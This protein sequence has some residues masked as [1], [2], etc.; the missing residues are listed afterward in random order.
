M[1]PN[2]RPRAVRHLESLEVRQLLSASS[3]KASALIGGQA[4]SK[5][6][7]VAKA[8]PVLPGSPGTDDPSTYWIFTRGESIDRAGQTVKVAVPLTS[9]YVSPPQGRKTTNFEFRITP[10]QGPLAPFAV[11][12][13]G[14]TGKAVSNVS[15]YRSGDVI[16]GVVRLA[17]ADYTIVVRG[18]GKSTGAFLAQVHLVG[19]ETGARTVTQGD[20][21]AIR[22]VL[23]T[24][25]GSVRD[26]AATAVDDLNDNGRISAADLALVRQ[27]LGAEDTT[28]QYLIQN[29]TN[30]I[31]SNQIHLAFYGKTSATGPFQYFDLSTDK[32]AS[33]KDN[34]SKFPVISGTS[35]HYIPNFTLDKVPNGIEIP[36]SF[37]NISG[38]LPIAIGNDIIATVNPDGTVA[39]PTPNNASDPNS[40]RIWELAEATQQ[41]TSQGWNVNADTSS[42]D[43]FGFPVTVQLTPVDIKHPG[44]AGVFLN[45]ASLIKKFLQGAVGGLAPFQL[46]VTDA[47]TTAD[48]ISG[49]LVPYR[50]LSPQ[51]VLKLARPSGPAGAEYDALNSYFDKSIN[52][53][54]TTY[55]SQSLTLYSV[56]GKTA[57]TGTV[58]M[59][60]QMGTDGQ[61]HQYYVIQFTSG[62]NDSYN[63][64]YPFFSTNSN[65]KTTL[66]GAN[67][68]PPPPSWWVP[69]QLDPNASPTF[70][71]FAAAGVFADNAF[72]PSSTYS[73]NAGT[74]GDLENQIDAAMIRGAAT[75]QVT[76]MGMVPGAQQMTPTNGVY[77]A[78]AT[79]AD[80]SQ[81]KVGMY[82]KGPGFTGPTTVASIGPDKT[83]IT[84]QS[85]I[86]I[87]PINESPLTFASFYQ[88]G[89]TW[90]YYG[91]FFHDPAVSVDG[92]AYGTPFDDQGGFSSDISADK[93]T[94]LVISI[95]WNPGS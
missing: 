65:A 11:K 39:N 40:N 8:I 22:S 23:A 15:F 29:N 83:Q 14:P 70:M 79:V 6:A 50:I 85:S 53:F 32:F 60:P 86:P 82:V 55:Q 13:V 16:G 77:T 1:K 66:Y 90:S 34:M 87:F 62:A 69:P 19:D 76:T 27:N 17:P 89:G 54:F 58:K 72:Q 43:Q 63:V 68:P 24:A 93:A 9:N 45:R 52:D 71:V 28:V 57:Y 78:T 75:S 21:A 42:V 30:G 18:R 84:L 31:P 59:I 7:T 80:N 61:T 56:D 41:P 20:V 26:T 64:Y 47:G 25:H 73:G 95:G 51:A 12:I 35:T 37:T 33:V 92:L 3:L 5:S 81:I 67:A 94:K 38:E 88:P 4:A 2:M 91:E 44:G 36:S 46:L 48:P 10:T 49:A 74:L